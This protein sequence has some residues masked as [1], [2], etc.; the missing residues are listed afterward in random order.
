MKGQVNEGVDWSEADRAHMSGLVQEHLGLVVDGAKLAMALAR[1]WPKLHAAGVPTPGELPRALAR[2]SAGDP[3]WSALIPALTIN[4]TYFRREA[5]QLEGFAK[6]V[7]PGLRQRAWAEKRPLRLLSAAC[8][9]GEEAYSLAEIL[10]GPGTLGDEVLG[11]DL[12]PE[13][14]A[15]A[16]AGQYGPNSLRGL[17]E[18]WRDRILAP[19]GPQRWGVRPALHGMVRFAQVNLLQVGERLQWQRF[20]AIFCRNVLIYFDKATQ[21]EVVRQ[22]RGLLHPDSCLFLGHSEIFFD[23]ELG[24]EPVIAES[25]CWFRKDKAVL[26]A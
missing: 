26:D 18:A 22:L 10:G 8:A 20:D 21:L 11:I 7:L 24:M 16:E 15:I 17:S 19:V 6:E 12:D 5:N 23:Q 14:L 3:L 25:A 4:E 9:T 13:A 2:G 1:A